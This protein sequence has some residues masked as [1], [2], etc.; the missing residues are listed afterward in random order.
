MIIQVDGIHVDSIIGCYDYERNNPQPIQINLKV[1]L[2]SH[3]WIEQDLLNTTVNYDE[4]IDYTKSVVVNTN[5]HLLESLAQHITQ[6]LLNK[7]LLIHEVEIWL[8]KPVINGIKADAIKIY[9][10]HCR[11]FE[12]ALALGSNSG[13]LPQQQLIT[14][15]EMLGE[16]MSKIKIGGFYE[17]LPVGYTEQD[18]FINTAISGYTDLKPEQLLSKIKSI[19]KLM[20]KTEIIINGPRVIDID[21]ILFSNLTYVHNFLAVPH[22]EAHNRDFVLKPLA[23]IVPDWVHPDLNKTIKQL[24]DELPQNNSSILKKINYYK[25]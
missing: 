10:K 23:D 18:N 3:N 19:E 7:F 12:V 6:E 20:G 4:L 13:F 5:F 25:E 2:Y 24:L 15:I 22:K 1:K 8:S 17:T 14:A 16:V 11:H 21:L 9:F